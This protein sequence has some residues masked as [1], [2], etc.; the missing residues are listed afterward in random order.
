VIVVTVARKPLAEGSV[1]SNTLVHGCGA[2]NVDGTRVAS[3]KGNP[4]VHLGRW[5]ANL[6]LGHL[7]GCRLVGSRRV[8]STGPG[9]G[10]GFKDVK[11]SGQVGIGSYTR[12]S[13]AGFADEDGNETVDAW[14]CSPGCPVANLD[15]QSGIQKSGVAV[16]R[17]GGGQFFG[18]T[19]YMGTKRT[20]EELARPDAGFGDEGG[21]SRFFKQVGGRRG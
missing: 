20:P 21:A 13:F 5:P 6:I 3:A 15:A 19:T 7:D 10:G 8:K 2:V 4:S 16:Q 9:I 12:P 11:Y 18:T 14:E 17:H 1:A